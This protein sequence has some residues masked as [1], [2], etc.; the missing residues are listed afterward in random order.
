[1]SALTVS[2]L[3][4]YPVKS[5]APLAVEAARVTPRGLEHDRR[6]MLVD[7]DARFLTGREHPRLTQIRSR[8]EDGALAIDAPGM[9]AL[10]LPLAEPEGVRRSVDL[11]GSPCPAVYAGEGYD[12]W[13]SELLGARCHLVR[14][15]AACG[16]PVDPDVGR[17]GDEVSFADGY[18][19]L[20]IAEASLAD[21]NARLAA[22]VSMRRFRPNVVV[23]GG[24]AFAEDGWRRLRIG[25]V[26]FDGVENCSR[27]VFTTIDPDTGEKHPDL[28]P[29]RTLG[30]YRRRPEGGVYFGQ[31]LIPRS[32]GTV[33][34]G[35]PIEVIE[36][37]R[38]VPG[39]GRS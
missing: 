32:E 11:W 15:T 24:E 21:L 25:S 23:A 37:A 35:D 1:M 38:P 20:L 28:E 33:R 34:V 12:A 18:P 13:F 17:D 31:N 8:L 7:E 14:M 6:W 22:P 4:V 26:E 3:N 10:E 5:T 27:C 36:R 9:P 19:L 30:S 39:L 2:G 16:R 29:L